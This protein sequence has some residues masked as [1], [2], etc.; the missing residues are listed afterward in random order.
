MTRLLASYVYFF[1]AFFFW[2]LRT[3]S[4]DAHARTFVYQLRA[5]IK[6]LP[7]SGI[8]F[9]IEPPPRKVMSINSKMCSFHA[10]GVLNVVECSSRILCST[11]VARQRAS[12][13]VRVI[14]DS[15]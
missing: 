7:N 15:F 10:T 12:S 6:A 8:D 9:V 13:F 1:F 2:A 14:M 5:K 3:T 11:K 4:F